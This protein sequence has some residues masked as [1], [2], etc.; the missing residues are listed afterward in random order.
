VNVG[1]YIASALCLLTLVCII[2]LLIVM[3]PEE[4]PEKSPEKGA[5]AAGRLSPPHSPDP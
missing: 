3:D 2:V 5:A 1:G 4:S